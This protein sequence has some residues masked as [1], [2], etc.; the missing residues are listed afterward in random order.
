VIGAEIVVS[1]VRVGQQVPGDHRMERPTATTAQ[2]W[3][4]RRAMRRLAGPG[5]L[6]IVNGGPAAKAASATLNAPLARTVIAGSG[7]RADVGV[8]CA[9][10]RS[11]PCSRR[12]PRF[13]GANKI[14]QSGMKRP[15]VRKVDSRRLL[16][17]QI[18]AAR[19]SCAELLGLLRS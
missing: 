1:G 6:R 17:A 13:V 4:R 12:G 2:R 10:S 9:G 15:G 14:R 11:T 19:L 7:N 3:P 8:R 18:C 5:F 16:A